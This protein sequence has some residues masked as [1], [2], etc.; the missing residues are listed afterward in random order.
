MGG[1]ATNENVDE[2][3]K[4]APEE[5]QNN[6]ELNEVNVN[7]ATNQDE[8]HID[9]AATVASSNAGPVEEEN[10]NNDNDNSFEEANTHPY[11]DEYNT[12]IA[13]NIIIIYYF[14]VCNNIFE[15]VFIQN[16]NN[17]IIK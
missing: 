6:V 9:A 17:K 15:A 8:A 12:I 3:P 5:N 11:S 2:S 7:N 14:H 13:M 10:S 1:A 16:N 4:A